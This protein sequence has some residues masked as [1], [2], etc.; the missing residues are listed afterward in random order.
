MPSVPAYDEIHERVGGEVY[1][2]LPAYND[3]H[4]AIALYSVP[5]FRTFEFRPTRYEYA[6]LHALSS[7]FVCGVVLL[8]CNNWLFYVMSRHSLYCTA[9]ACQSFQ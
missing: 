8:E 5:K 4:G 1:I 6:R 9:C 7:P 2:A 3:I